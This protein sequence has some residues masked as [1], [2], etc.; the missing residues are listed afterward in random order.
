MDNGRKLPVNN[1]QS[2]SRSGCGWSRNEPWDPKEV[3]FQNVHL[4]LESTSLVLAVVGHC[5]GDFSGMNWNEDP[6]K[7]DRG[8]GLAG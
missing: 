2:T 5:R 3:K 1:L 8:Q 6:G 4:R 7:L